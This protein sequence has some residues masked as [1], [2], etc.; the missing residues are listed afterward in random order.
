MRGGGR[1][2]RGASTSARGWAR[3]SSTVWGI[4]TTPASSGLPW[5]MKSRA[6]LAVGQ[7]PAA[8]GVD[9]HVDVVAPP[10]PAGCRG[11]RADARRS[12]GSK[13]SAA[14]STPR[15][16]VCRTPPPRRRWSAPDV[17]LR[18]LDRLV[19]VEQ[20]VDGE[21][22][23]V[24]DRVDLAAV[25]LDPCLGRPW[26]PGS[27]GSSPARPRWCSKL[28]SRYRAPTSTG[29][30]SATI[31][32]CSSSIARWQKRSIVRHV[33]GDED[34]RPCPRRAGGGTR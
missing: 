33:V 27:G 23:P 9:A 13:R 1:A 29:A 21:R 7:H 30:P 16:V 34:D 19:H 12:P 8:R 18:A 26:P 24:L 5:T 17:Q 25:D 2:H 10:S 14:E 15:V 3:S 6:R 11:A 28:S 4:V 20:G 31:R 22:R 32:P